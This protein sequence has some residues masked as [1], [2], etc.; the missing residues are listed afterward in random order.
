MLGST[1]PYGIAIGGGAADAPEGM[2]ATSV[3]LKR[4]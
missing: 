4:H 3:M 1:A 2:P